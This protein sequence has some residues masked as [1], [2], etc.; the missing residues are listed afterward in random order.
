[1]MAESRKNDPDKMISAKEIVKSY[2]ISYQ[3]VNHYTDF[4]LL[5]VKAKEVMSD[6]MTGSWWTSAYGRLLS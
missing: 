4:G 3:T 6:S 2:N 1:M 5:E